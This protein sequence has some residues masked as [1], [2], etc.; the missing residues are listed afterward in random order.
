DLRVV[1]DHD[2]E[3]D[4]GA[5]RV[6]P[7]DARGDG[8]LDAVPVEA[9]LPCRAAALERGRLDRL[10][11]RVVE[12]G[13]ARLGRVIIGL[14]RGSRRLQVRPRTLGVDLDDPDVAV[15]PLSLHEVYA[16]R[17]AKVDERVGASEGTDE[18]RGQR[19]GGS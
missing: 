7:R 17:G 1:V 15:A 4:R 16:V 12:V 11:R 5:A 18:R 13:R 19:G 8:N 14:D 9:D 3:R 2:L 10:P 6:E